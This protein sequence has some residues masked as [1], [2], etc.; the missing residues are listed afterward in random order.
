MSNRTVKIILISAIVILIFSSFFFFYSRSKRNELLSELPKQEEAKNVSEALPVE[1]E[2]RTGNKYVIDDQTNINEIKEVYNNFLNEV[3]SA[4]NSDE[5][6]KWIDMR[7]KTGMIINLGNFTAA[8]GLILD[9]NLWK[10]LDKNDFSLFYCPSEDEYFRGRGIFLNVRLEE[11]YYK[12]EIKFTKEWESNMVYDVR[13]IVFPSLDLN[14]DNLKS[15][16]LKFRDISKGRVVDFR[17]EKEIYQHLYYKIVDHSIFITNN[18]EC[19]DLV[20][21]S[22]ESL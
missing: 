19:F 17:D 8:T 16:N 2:K 7:E 5:K 15:Q 3:N 22:V 13:N 9:S 11:D 10:I 21:E 1:I 20:S 12:N 14:L 18:L 4:K 6:L